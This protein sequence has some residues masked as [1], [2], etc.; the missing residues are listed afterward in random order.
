LGESHG[1]PALDG[2]RRAQ[3]GPAFPN[4]LALELGTD[5]LDEL[6]GEHGE[7]EM[8]INPILAG[9]MDRTQTEFG[10]QGT[11]HGFQV[12]ERGLGVP[13]RLFVP[14][15]EVGTQAID[16]RIGESGSPAPPSK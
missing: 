10:F 13:E 6:I 7:E 4:A 11:E 1:D 15:Q 3:T 12:G 9:L 8:S 5:E 14:I 16:P 2:E